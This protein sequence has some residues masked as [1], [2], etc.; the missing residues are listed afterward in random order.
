MPGGKDIEVPHLLPHRPG[1]PVDLGDAVYLVAKEFDPDD[2]VE[3]PGD[4]VDGISFYPEPSRHEFDLIP[5]VEAR[6]QVLDHLLSRDGIPHLQLK[7]H[8]PVVFGPA[9]TIDAGDR[10]YHDHIR[11]RE[12]R[13]GRR[14]AHHLEL[15]VD[16]GIFL[17]ILVLCRE[18][19]L[20]LVIVIVGDEVLHA[21]IGEELPEL[22]PES[23][24]PAS[25][26]G[27]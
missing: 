23:G 11:S 25:C 20:R 21:I 16:L 26:Y 6:N 3:I 27:R 9:E 17:N 14:E 15:R 7:P 10:G 4:E 8:V 19:G 13:C 5:L 22:I 2:I 1:I 12:D 24:L 18:V